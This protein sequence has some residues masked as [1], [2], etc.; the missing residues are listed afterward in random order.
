MFL[1]SGVTLPMIHNCALPRCT[2]H[3][4]GPARSPVTTTS[5]MT[6]LAASPA[7]P[8]AARRAPP[9]SAAPTT[10]EALVRMLA[11]RQRDEFRFARHRR[12]LPS[13]PTLL[14]ALDS[15]VRGGDKIPPNEARRGKCGSAQQQCSG[16]LERS[17]GVWRGGREYR[18]LPLAQRVLADRERALRHI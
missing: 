12:E 8:G 5:S 13:R 14:R 11:L 2:C 15:L 9:N 18:Q 7:R 17:Q 3:S 10:I 4:P 6:G 1:G 16:G